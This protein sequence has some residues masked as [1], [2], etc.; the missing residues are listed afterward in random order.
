MND[1]P[2]PGLFLFSLFL[3]MLSGLFSGSATAPRTLNGALRWKLPTNSPK[4]RNGLI[5][6]YMQ[7]TRVPRTSLNLYGRGLEIMHTAESAVKT[8]KYHD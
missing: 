2:L 3:T 5:L 6:E 4:I 1:I 7:A 8:V